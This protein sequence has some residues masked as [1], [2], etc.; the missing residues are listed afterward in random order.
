MSD[1]DSPPTLRRFRLKLWTLMLLPVAAA[2][3]LC[4]SCLFMPARHEQ[5]WSEVRLRFKVVD[6]KDLRP[7]SNPCVEIIDPIVTRISGSRTGRST[8]VQGEVVH[9]FQFDRVTRG[10]LSSET[11]N[12]EGPFVEVSADAHLPVKLPLAA[13]TGSALSSWNLPPPV[14]EVRLQ[15]GTV[16]PGQI[17]NIAGLYVRS[18][19][20]EE[21]LFIGTDHQYVYRRWGP[22]GYEGENQGA[23]RFASGT[24]VL[25]A[26]RSTGFS[27]IEVVGSDFTLVPW[28]ARTYLIRETD[29][30]KL[31][32]YTYTRREPRDASPGPFFLRADD[33]TKKVT[34][35]PTLP[36]RWQSRWPR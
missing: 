31:W 19:H 20:G 22:H 23:I 30:P 28:G 33:W 35:P 10:F 26:P 36:P 8:S 2:L 16:T 21:E 24:V 12:F 7:V 29:F 3:L 32:L 34:T 11:V 18:D 4:L 13:L 15:P 5:R 25:Q 27:W 17:E 1:I 6:S 9:E 14:I